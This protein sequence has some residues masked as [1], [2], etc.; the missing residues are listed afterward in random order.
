MISGGQIDKWLSSWPLWESEQK[1]DN[2][3]GYRPPCSHSGQPDRSSLPC[4]IHWYSAIQLRVSIV[5]KSLLYILQV[6]L[7]L[8][9]IFFGPNTGFLKYHFE[10]NVN[11]FRKAAIYEWLMYAYIWPYKVEFFFFF[12]PQQVSIY[13]PRVILCRKSTKSTD[14]PRAMPRL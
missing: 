13:T 11:S 6:K 9:I 1:L 2:R 12:L 5:L 3:Q 10:N 7:C 4:S 14:V 8:Q